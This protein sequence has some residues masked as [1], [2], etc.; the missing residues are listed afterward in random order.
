MSIDEFRRLLDAWGGDPARWP[1][2]ARR[3]AETLLSRSPEAR[4]LRDEA[5]AFDALL[6]SAPAIEP[7]EALRTRLMDLPGNNRQERRRGGSG[8]RFGLGAFLPRFA[9]LAAAVLIGF[10]VG[11][12]SL[13]APTQSYASDT[14][15][16]NISDYVFGDTAGDDAL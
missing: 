7:S 5:A 2:E 3:D 4:A 1:R 13:F 8:A 9:G 10:Y 16:L 14:D 15:T 12:T 11:S 6:A